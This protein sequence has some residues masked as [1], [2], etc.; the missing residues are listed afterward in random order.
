V[1]WRIEPLERRTH[2]RDSFRCGKP[3]LDHYLQQIARRAAE[4][5]T[6]RTWVA[7][8]PAAPADPDGRRPVL[9]YYAVSMH[10]IDVSAL[11]EDRRAGLPRSQVPAALLSRLAVDRR[12]QGRGLGRLLLL[13]AL[14]RIYDAAQHVAAHAVVLDAIDADARGFYARYGFLELID[15]P[16][17]LFLPMSSLRPLFA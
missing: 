3:E 11:P 10:S 12:C 7:I 4:V 15:H 2:D 16:R 13:D 8:D 5:G 6:G 1:A 9:G 14:R 17:H